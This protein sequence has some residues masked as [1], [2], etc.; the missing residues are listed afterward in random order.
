MKKELILNKLIIFPLIVFLLI[1]VTGCSVGRFAQTHMMESVKKVNKTDLKLDFQVDYNPTNRS[2]SIKLAHQPYSIYKSKISLIDLG[3]G[4]AAVGIWGYVFYDNWDHDYTFDFTDDTFDWYDSEWWEKAVLIGV[5]TD[6]L[7]YWAFSY[8]I[9]RKKVKLMRQP[10]I[11]HPYRIELP[12]HGNLGMDYNTITGD[13]NIDIKDFISDIGNP[14]YLNNI[15]Y[16]KFRVSTE[17]SGMQ[18]RKYYSVPVQLNSPIPPITKDIG[19]DVEWK[20]NRI[21]AGDRAILIITV[22]NTGR[23]ELR[24]LTAM[25]ASTNPNFAGFELPFGSIPIGES[26]TNVIGFSTDAESSVQNTTVTLQ[27]RSSERT[28]A[29]KVSKVLSI[30]R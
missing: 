6:I 8:P 5:P 13:E 23:V 14:S 30:I 4:L 9:D 2:L 29:Q 25:T 1:S 28:V 17:T 11:N 10:L 26:K 7:L 20:S 24:D 19:I 3:L 27:F 18:H 12:D 22:E 16:M 15:D 21:R